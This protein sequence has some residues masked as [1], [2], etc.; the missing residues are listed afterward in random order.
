MTGASKVSIFVYPF[1]G[2]LYGKGN[3]IIDEPSLEKIFDTLDDLDYI[4]CIVLRK[5]INGVTLPNTSEYHSF[6][7]Y[8]NLSILKRF[9]ELIPDYTFNKFYSTSNLQP[10]LNSFFN[11]NLESNP[12]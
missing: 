10:N 1:T 7:S 3:F 11:H 6:L 4:N 12:F 9:E 8:E 2:L 5:M